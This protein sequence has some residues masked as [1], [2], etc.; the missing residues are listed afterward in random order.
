MQSSTFEE[1]SAL[2]LRLKGITNSIN[3]ANEFGSEKQ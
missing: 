2:A 1:F 3:L